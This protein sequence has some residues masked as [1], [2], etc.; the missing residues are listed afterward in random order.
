MR[1]EI[2][3]KES[4]PALPTLLPGLILV[5]GVS[6]IAGWVHTSVVIGNTHPVSDVVVAIILG[7]IVKA[8]VGIPAMFQPGVTFSLKKILKVSI[9]LLGLGL[10]FSSVVQTGIKA[11]LII[12]LCMV[13]ALILTA[14]IGKSL[15]LSQR[16]AALIGVGTAICGATAIV[17]TAPAI[18]ADD[19]EVTYSVATITLFGVLAIFVYPLLG[20]LLVLSD[21]QFGTW[22]GTAVNETAQVV[23]A[24]FAYSDA[25]GKIATVVKLTRTAMLAP[26]VLIMGFLFARQKAEHSQENELPG[27]MRRRIDLI[28]IFPW[29]LLGF[30]SL[31]LLRTIGD[32]TLQ[33]TV[34][35]Q[36]WETLLKTTG[37]VAKFLIVM[38]MAGVGL[39]TDFGKMRSVGFRPF[40]VGLAASTIMAVVSLALIRAAG[41]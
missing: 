6:V 25:A 40:L 26:V 19:N 1:T 24:G 31:A 23:A 36:S 28:K 30:V 29:F 18:D 21:M 17:A 41:V 7:M 14:L 12:A 2:N 27:S 22:A 15:R 11:A 13:A 39:M 10:S 20:K 38:A 37:Q 3:P 8:V 5:T 35:G 33:G 32:A 16:L 9:I 4:A 34:A